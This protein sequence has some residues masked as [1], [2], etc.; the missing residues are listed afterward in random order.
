MERTD[1]PGLTIRTAALGTGEHCETLTVDVAIER[2]HNPGPTVWLDLVFTDV[3]AARALLHEQIGFHELAV[4]DALS[5]HERPSLQEFD[6]EL[7]LVIPA[8]VANEFVEVAFFLRDHSLVTVSPRNLPVIDQWFARW[9]DHPRR[10][11]DHPAFVMHSIIDGFVDDYFPYIDRIE[12]EIDDIGDLIFHGETTHVAEILQLKRRLLEARRRLIPV[13]DILNSLLRRDS[14]RIPDAARPYFQDVYDHTLR[15]TEQ[16]DISRDTLASLLDVHLSNVSNNLNEIVKRM[17]VLSTLLMTFALVAGI[18]GMNF[19]HMPEL[20]W[21]YGYPFSIG[22]M[23]VLG[24]V[25]LILFR[26]MKW[27]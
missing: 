13:R 16:V 5:T 18:Y 23:V 24:V 2:I 3:E 26:W 25:E 8:V 4:E 11:G 10:I 20:Q 22:L 27:L 7:F 15:V 14:I 21:A 19:A 9:A 12:D 1:L 6:L 17:T